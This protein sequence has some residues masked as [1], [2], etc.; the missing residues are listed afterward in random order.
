LR[1]FWACSD[2]LGLSGREETVESEFEDRVRWIEK[3]YA[4]GRKRPAVVMVREF[5]CC[6]GAKLVMLVSRREVDGV[7]DARVYWSSW[8]RRHAEEQKLVPLV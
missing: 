5:R 3:S 4:G 1:S 7:E 6:D 8:V 2:S